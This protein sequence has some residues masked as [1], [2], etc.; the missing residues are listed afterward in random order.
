M[1]TLR[2]F[3]ALAI[4]ATIFSSSAQADSPAK[5]TLVDGTTIHVQI[6][7][8]SNSEVVYAVFQG[9]ATKV[10]RRISRNQIAQIEIQEAVSLASSITPSDQ[11]VAQRALNAIGSGHLNSLTAN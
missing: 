3:A 10:V 6:S 1:T 2:N 4:V 7:D 9:Q 11:S 5:L 8:R